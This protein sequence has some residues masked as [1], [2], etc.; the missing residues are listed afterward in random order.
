MDAPSPVRRSVW[1][2]SLRELLLLMIAVAA[3]LGWGGLLYQQYRSFE[4]S[5]F[6]ANNQT[7]KQDVIAV[8]QEL[9]EETGIQL[10]VSSIESTG[11]AAVT[12]TIVHRVPAS[13]PRAAVLDAL[14]K[15]ALVKMAADD[16]R[17]GSNGSGS[18]E[19]TSSRVFLYERGPVGGVFEI[20][21]TDAGS[22]AIVTVQMRESRG[23]FH[24]LSIRGQ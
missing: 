9:G 15:R 5:P 12:R 3:F 20:W 10:G 17:T 11:T 19:K 6:F 23:R 14:V 24:S 4:P 2:F 16:C 8:C 7:W 21:I 22:E 1:R 13:L 18:D